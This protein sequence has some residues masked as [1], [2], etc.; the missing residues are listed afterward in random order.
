MG[1]SP[2]GA[3]TFVDPGTGETFWY[4]SNGISKPFFEAL[5]ALFAR[6]SGAGG[7]RIVILVLDNAGWHSPE[8]LT[9]P[10]GIRLLF[11]PPYSPELQPAEHLWRRS[12]RSSSTNTSPLWPTSKPHSPTAASH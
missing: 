10:E 9:V 5:L 7:E 4:L 11:L 6:E 8:G 2:R 1:R 3:H 12:T